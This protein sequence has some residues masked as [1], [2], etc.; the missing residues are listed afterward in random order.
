MAKNAHYMQPFMRLLQ[1]R[2]IGEATTVKMLDIVRTK[3]EELRIELA[4]MLR[5]RQEDNLRARG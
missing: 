4:A 2:N 5:H 1:D 3:H